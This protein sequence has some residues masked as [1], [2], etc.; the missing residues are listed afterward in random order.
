[1]ENG[2]L[3]RMYVGQENNSNDG[4]CMNWSEVDHKYRNSSLLGNH[5]FCRKPYNEQREEL[6]VEDKEGCFTNQGP[7]ACY[8]STCDRY[9]TVET[10]VSK[11]KEIIRTDSC[12]LIGIFF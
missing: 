11:N 8:V 10:I 6:I 3:E 2:R 12:L 5:N 4:P 7:V 9:V 1:M